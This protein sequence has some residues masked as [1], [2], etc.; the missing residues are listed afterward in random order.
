MMPKS[1]VPYFFV[2]II[3]KLQNN[4]YYSID[5]LE[6]SNDNKVRNINKT[7]DTEAKIMARKNYSNTMEGKT[8]ERLFKATGN[9][10][11]LK[12]WISRCAKRYFG[13]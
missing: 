3:G 7:H 6:V 12:I 2:K 9:S 5:K 13:K 11:F 8:L 10:L 4:F 1:R